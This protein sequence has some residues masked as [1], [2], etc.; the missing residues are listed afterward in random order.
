MEAF[1]NLEKSVNLA[2]GMKIAE[3]DIA[4]KMEAQLLETQYARKD[5]VDLLEESVLRG[6]HAL[7]I[8]EK[9]VVILQIRIEFAKEINAPIRI[10]NYQIHTQGKKPKKT[11]ETSWDNFFEKLKELEKKHNVT[12]I[13][14]FPGFILKKTKVFPQPFTEGQLIN[15]KIMSPGSFNGDVIAVAENRAISVQKCSKKSGIIKLKITRAKYNTFFGE[16]IN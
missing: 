10:Q 14:E 13:G 9:Q 1:L 16:I 7:S 15:A 12:L 8:Q 11:G 4:L 3:K 2:I 5:I 6:V